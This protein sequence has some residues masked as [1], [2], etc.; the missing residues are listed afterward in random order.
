MRA[1]VRPVVNANWEVS[2]V[3]E[4]EGVQSNDR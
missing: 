1:I 2:R 4:R 3:R